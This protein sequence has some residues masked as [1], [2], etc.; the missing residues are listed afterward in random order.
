MAGKDGGAAFCRVAHVAFAV[1]I[2]A[3]VGMHL[4]QLI[5][6][7]FWLAVLG[8][9]ALGMVGAG[10]LV[11]VDS[12]VDRW[13]DHRRF[14]RLREEYH[15][16]N[17]ERAQR[18]MEIVNDPELT[19]DDKRRQYVRMAEEVQFDPDSVADEAPA[20]RPF[21][22]RLQ[23]WTLDGIG[24]AFAALVLM[25]VFVDPVDT[26]DEANA[27][28]AGWVDIL[29]LVMGCLVIAGVSWAHRITHVRGNLPHP[30]RDGWYGRSHG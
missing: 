26:S 12:A 5:T 18:Y 27:R 7:G 1:A 19:P 20:R 30:S 23:A 22:Y 24:L 11:I 6:A 16:V 28:M 25:T 21:L 9:A 10:V 17:A 14:E 2:L 29:A 4:L 15:R 8:L 13:K 3:C